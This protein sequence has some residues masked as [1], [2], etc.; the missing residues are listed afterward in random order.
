MFRML[1]RC[2]DGRLRRTGFK[3]SLGTLGMI[4]DQLNQYR[5]AKPLSW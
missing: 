1:P 2:N 4:R 5:N 3:A